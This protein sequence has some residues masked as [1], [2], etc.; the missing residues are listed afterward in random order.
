[1]KY[2]RLLLWRECSV[3]RE[4]ECLAHGNQSLTVLKE[5][6]IEALFA[7]GSVSCATAV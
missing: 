7:A 4:E 6:L 5:I 1:M 3:L 2:K